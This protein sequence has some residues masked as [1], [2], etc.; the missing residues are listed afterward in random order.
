[1]ISAAVV[2]LVARDVTID[3]IT[4][5][6]Q[7]LV[8]ARASEVGR[9][10][11]KAFLQ[12]D[13]IAED[14]EIRLSTRNADEF[15][16][17]FKGRL[18]PEISYIFWAGKSGDFFT[19]EGARGNISDRDYFK[20]IL[21]EGAKRVVSDAVISKADGKPVLVLARPIIGARLSVEG[22]VA[23][24]ISLD[25]FSAY[26]SSIVMGRNGYGYMIDRRGIIIAHKKPE[27]ILKLNFLD[28]AKDGWVGLDAA[29]KA[30]LASDSAVAQYKRPDGVEITMFSHVVPG[31]PEWRMGITVP[32]AELNEEAVML[33]KTLMYIFAA[34]LFMA[35]VASLLLARSI[36][37]PIKAVT[38][39]VEL[40]AQGNLRA[41]GR[42]A[43]ELSR[44]SRRRDEIGTA[45]KAA[46]STMH[47]LESIV[48]QIAQAAQ[49]VSAGASEIAAAAENVS[50]C[51]SEQAASVEELSSSTEELASSARQ[52]ADSSH[53]ADVL[54]KRVGNEAELSGNVVKETVSHMRDIAGKIIIVEEIARQTN[55]LALN[56][57]IKAARAGEAGKGFA[58]V[59][60]EVRKL[61]ERSAQA[62]REIT[63]LAGLSVTRAEEAGVRLEGL[64]PDIRKTSELAEEIAAAARE[65]STGTDQIASAVEQF[66][67]VVQR[68]S[69]IAEELASTAEELASQS[70]L[71]N[72]VISFF[73]VSNKAEMGQ[74]A[75]ATQKSETGRENREKS[76]I[77]GENAGTKKLVR[78]VVKRLADR[79]QGRRL[80]Q[81]SD[82]A[83]VGA[84][85]MSDSDFE[86]FLKKLEAISADLCHGNG[87]RQRSC[88]QIRSSPNATCTV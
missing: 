86:V 65:Q 77:R 67:E 23:A 59:A 51:I 15:I 39:V 66:D 17:S 47:K 56:A 81:S 2:A 34:A 48:A 44:A 6:A 84:S 27:Y 64:L 74:A 38:G 5:D 45:V 76:G 13:L 70:E 9:M 58:V 35:V 73:K 10:A 3:L 14:R 12:I 83:E 32:T 54:T 42:L 20:K 29:G 71:M 25:Y 50:S 28:S 4:R 18:P 78:P 87:P 49:Q 52:N 22:I 68:N 69:S 61:A 19:S 30:A 33:V 72:S 16:G 53:G 41:E 88:L 8:L 43:S 1:M 55:L 60:T 21:N 37:R 40:L 63:D 11:E 79:D 57:A 85:A 36:T 26:V 24:C 46:G 82:N 62:A 75:A 31:V 7:A 80:Y